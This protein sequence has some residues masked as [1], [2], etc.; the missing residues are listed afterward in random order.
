MNLVVSMSEHRNLRRKTETKTKFEFNRNKAHSLIADSKLQVDESKRKM[1][2]NFNKQFFYLKIKYFKSQ[3]YHE[4][5]SN[6]LD[7]LILSL[8]GSQSDL[9]LVSFDLKCSVIYLKYKI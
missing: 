3:N 4:L 7:K 2:A 5:S 8:L 6:Q 1:E 9:S